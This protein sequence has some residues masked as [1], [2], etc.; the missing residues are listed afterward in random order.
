[1]VPFLVLAACVAVLR[2]FGALGVSSLESCTICLRGGL[3]A[4]FVLTASAHWGRRRPDLIV[5]LTGCLE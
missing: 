1:M 4:M 3:A 5:M 2:M